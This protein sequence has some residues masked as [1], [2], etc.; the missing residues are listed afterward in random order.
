MTTFS[1]ATMGRVETRRSSFR[2]CTIA[3]MRPSCGTRR[4][5]ISRLAM[6]LMRETM[7][8]FIEGGGFCAS[9]MMPSMR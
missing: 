1:P 7:A 8:A 2:P 3:R 5:A 4:S 6:I 9:N